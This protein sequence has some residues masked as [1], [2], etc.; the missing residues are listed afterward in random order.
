[1]IFLSFYFVNEGF[2][3]TR[4]EY[5]N[6]SQKFIKSY[7]ELSSA[8]LGKIH[9]TI[10]EWVTS[11]D[12]SSF[13]E[14]NDFIVSDNKIA[15]YIYLDEPE[16][17][18]KIPIEVNVE[19]SDDNIAVAFVSSEQINQISQL[20][21][22]E[23]ISLPIKARPPPIPKLVQETEIEDANLIEISIGITI[24]MAIAIGGAVV[25]SKK[26]KMRKHL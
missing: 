20:D 24:V 11:S 6:A 16:S 1:L 12:P 8:E 15:V 3:Q 4:E 13:A 22:V 23:Q 25:Y 10:I 7:P 5:G 9:P 2:S 21:F 17:I 18:S 26:K 14:K 19:A